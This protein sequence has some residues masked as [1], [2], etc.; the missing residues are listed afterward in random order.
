M[1]LAADIVQRRA[2]QIRHSRLSA[3]TFKET[4][5]KETSKILLC[6]CNKLG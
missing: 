2:E 3:S 5:N 1:L 6:A 4:S